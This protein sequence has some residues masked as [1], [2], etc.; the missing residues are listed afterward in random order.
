MGN[1]L[2]SS[3]AQRRH[4]QGIVPHVDGASVFQ[5][6]LGLSGLY[7]AGKPIEKHRR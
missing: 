7:H 6:I 5:G 1:Q 3:D 4:H 2:K